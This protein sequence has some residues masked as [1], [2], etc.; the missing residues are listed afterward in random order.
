MNKNILFGGIIVVVLVVL[1]G[2]FYYQQTNQV[3]NP[4][5]SNNQLMEDNF[6]KD[7]VE[8]SG[9]GE[10]YV[11]DEQGSS[12]RWHAERI[13]GN[14]HDGSAPF[15]GKVVVKDD[16]FVNGAF[17][18]DIANFTS[19]D[20]NERFMTHVKSE[21][22]FEVESYPT[23][24]LVIN[25]VELTDQDDVYTVQGDLTIKGQTNSISFPATITRDGENIRATADFTIDRTRWGIV[26]DS[27]SIFSEIG[28][29]AIR[30]EIEF[31]LDLVASPE[32]E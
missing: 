26:Y 5:N 18:I 27:G 17:V 8:V 31:K 25:S 3:E 14:S 6:V 1:A 29:K 20:N 22:F 15:T 9:E 16:A 10:V 21:D 7:E 4:D 24:E 23:A 30:D 12:L 32:S 2:Y 13:V 11:V 19:D 28:D